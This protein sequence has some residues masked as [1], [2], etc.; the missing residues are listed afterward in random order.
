[1]RREPLHDIVP[2][3][4]DDDDIHHRGDHPGAVFDGFAAAQL[5]VLR[6]QE[7]GLAPELRDAG[8]ERYPR[9]GGRFGKD[10]GQH[11]AR[12]GALV[13]ARA[14]F[15]FQFHGALDELPQLSGAEIQ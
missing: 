5:C 9:A 6:R 11:G 3:G 12:E 15:P 7:H 14:V 13:C 4:A 8:L 2:E 1:M 10:H